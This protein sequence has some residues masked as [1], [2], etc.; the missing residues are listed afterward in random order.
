MCHLCGT[1]VN[2]CVCPT[3]FSSYAPLTPFHPV[4]WKRRKKK[5]THFFHNLGARELYYRTCSHFLGCFCSSFSHV[6]RVRLFSEVCFGE[7]ACTS[8]RL[9]PP[10]L[11]AH[12]YRLAIPLTS[13][14]AFPLPPIINREKL[15]FSILDKRFSLIVA[16]VFGVCAGCETV[17]STRKWCVK[18]WRLRRLRATGTRAWRGIVEKKFLMIRRKTVAWS[19]VD[20]FSPRPPPTLVFALAGFPGKTLFRQIGMGYENQMTFWIW[21]FR[22]TY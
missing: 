22:H 8:H 21:R 11:S 19:S 20:L 1:P 15:A 18:G 6:H 2:L 10:P 14:D 17:S 7:Q 12:I 4:E 3:K 16:L 9:P 13:F 5:R